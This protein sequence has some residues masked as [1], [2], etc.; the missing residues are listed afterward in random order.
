MP[1]VCPGATGEIWRSA[2][3]DIEFF[4]EITN[5]DTDP[6]RP[7]PESNGSN[8]RTTPAGSIIPR[9]SNEFHAALTTFQHVV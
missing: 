3:P 2:L 7:T 9:R 5:S 8:F 1:E 4:S 6:A